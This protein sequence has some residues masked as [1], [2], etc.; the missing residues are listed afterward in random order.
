[1][2]FEI[3]NQEKPKGV[4]KLWLEEDTDGLEE[5]T[6]GNVTLKGEDEKGNTKHII[7]FSNGKFFRLLSAEGL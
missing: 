4:I 7:R 2:K 3:R 5:D 1:M 6:N